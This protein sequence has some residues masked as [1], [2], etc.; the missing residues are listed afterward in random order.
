MGQI[1]DAGVSFLDAAVGYTLELVGEAS[2]D[3]IKKEI[4]VAFPPASAPNTPPHRRTGQLFEGVYY[5]DKPDESIVTIASS[6]IGGMV[7]EWLEF[8]TV[9]MT[10]RPYMTPAMDNTE[11]ICADAVRFGMNPDAASA[12]AYKAWSQG[13]SAITSRNLED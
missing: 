4:S 13:V 12:A 2:T 8:G 7:P 11:R 3:W 6:R 1:V 10:E 9:K 5:E